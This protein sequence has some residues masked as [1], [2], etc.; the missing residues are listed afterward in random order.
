MIIAQGSIGIDENAKLAE[1]AKNKAE[2]NGNALTIFKNDMSA[3]AQQLRA[4]LN[5]AIKQN[6][7]NRDMLEQTQDQMSDEIAQAKADGEN[8]ANMIRD[9][10]GNTITQKMA[11]QMLSQQS[12]V[13]GKLTTSESS[14]YDADPNNTVQHENGDVWIQIAQTDRKGRTDY[15]NKGHVIRS[16]IAMFHYLKDNN[17]PNG[18]WIEQNW[19]QEIMSVENLSALSADLGDIY[20]GNINGVHIVGGTL[21]IDINGGFDGGNDGGW[22]PLHWTNDGQQFNASNWWGMG[23][24]VQNGL[25]TMRGRRTWGSQDGGNYDTTMLGPNDIKLRESNNTGTGNGD[26]TDRVDIRSNYIEIASSYGT[27]KPDGTVGCGLYSDGTASIS[28]LLKV[29]NIEAGKAGGHVYFNSAVDSRY[30]ITAHVVGNKSDLSLKNVHGE[31]SNKRALAEILGTDIYNYT[32]K[33]DNE[34][35]NIGPIIDDVHGVN[36]SEYKTSEYLVYRG[37]EN[38]SIALQNAI[39]LLIGSVHELSNQNEQLLGKI[40]QLEMAK[41][42]NN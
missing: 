3:Y 20:A 23:M 19:D 5:N 12:L 34:I 38:D 41:N 17:A 27:P 4:D 37:G 22:N 31:F 40:T 25:M 7:A 14:P 29:P 16:A 26:I 33:G 11:D 15:D 13:E 30:S 21:G 10:V 28:S 36:N 32:Y 42:G 18:A 1:E 6:D 24:H 39:A 35:R 2:F 9:Q 8:Y